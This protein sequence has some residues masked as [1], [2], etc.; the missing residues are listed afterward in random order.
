MPATTTIPSRAAAAREAFLSTFATEATRRQ[1]RTYL[2]E[3]ITHLAAR[4][5][6]TPAQLPTADLLDED[7]ART[8]LTAAHR[9]ATRR[10]PGPNGPHTSARTNSMAAR[11]ATLNTFTRF[12]GQPLNLKPPTPEFAGRLTPLEAHRTLR[13][14][15][16]HQPDGMLTPTWQRSVAI[17]ATAVCTHAGFADLHPMRLAD[18]DL[19]HTPPRARIN[20][21]WYPLD[22]T[23]RD[24]LARWHTT[25]Q[26]ITAG[27]LKTLQGGNVEELWVTTAPGRPRNGRSAPPPGLPA[28]IRTLA[29][30]H[31]KLTASVL[32]TP[33]L[34]EQFCNTDHQEEPN[35]TSGRRPAAAPA[36]G[37]AARH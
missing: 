12:C 11:T 32:G 17:V 31:R 30:A 23:S 19:D 18:L 7:N 24:A 25:H 27:H 29:A 35:P 1:R 13:L 14:L 4:Q 28:A 8:W 26:A 2:D 10:R 20:R 16:A 22:T 37:P 34:L 33:L 36:P 6:C 3:Y 9:G 15:A 21:Q 5:Q